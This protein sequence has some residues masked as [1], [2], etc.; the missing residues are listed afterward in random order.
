MRL[1][2]FI[3]ACYL[4]CYLFLVSALFEPQVS[5]VG[6][7]VLWGRESIPSLFLF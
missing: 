3:I 7:V 5:A 6:E 1:D 2:F 4:E